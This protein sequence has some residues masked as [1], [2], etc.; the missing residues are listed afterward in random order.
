VGWSRAINAAMR[1]FD[2]LERKLEDIGAG[3]PNR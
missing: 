1:D 3:G 2:E